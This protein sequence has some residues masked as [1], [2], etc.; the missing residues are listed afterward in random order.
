MQQTLAQLQQLNSFYSQLLS[1]ITAQ[2][3]HLKL[4][5]HLLQTNDTQTSNTF[6]EESIK[7]VHK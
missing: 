4:L 3:Q 1:S 6:I 7:K 2:Q 5:I